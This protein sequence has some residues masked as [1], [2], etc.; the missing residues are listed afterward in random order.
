MSP[1]FIL[2][3]RT[4]LT[5]R[6]FKDIFHIDAYRIKR[7]QELVRL[8]LREILQEPR[9][10]VVIEWAEKVGRLLP[11]GATIRVKLRHGRGANER[12]VELP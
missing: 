5:R 11:K 1:T 2:M 4:P 7:A 9:N 10:L 12:L 6:R 3:R 8:G